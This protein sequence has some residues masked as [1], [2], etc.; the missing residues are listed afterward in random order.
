MRFSKLLLLLPALAALLAGCA[1]SFRGQTAGAIKSISIPPFENETAEFGIS[2][3]VTEELVRGFQRDGTLRI[4]STEQADAVLA[5][6]IT[7]VEDMPYTA[8]ADQTVEE[9]RFSMTCE[10]ELTDS[11]TQQVLWTQSYPA[12]AVYPYTGTLEYRDQA[13][14]EAVGKLQRDLL[15][16]IVGSW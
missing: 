15:N 9:Y 4:T 8:R 16:R 5:G 1:Y 12:W 3:R 7:R 6:R 11:R 10:I 2:E 14:Q 13:I